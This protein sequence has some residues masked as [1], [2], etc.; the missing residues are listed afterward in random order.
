MKENRLIRRICVYGVGGVGGYF[1][2]KIALAMAEHPELNYECY[3]IARGPHLEAIKRDGLTV[4]SPERTIVA[5][6][7]LATD[8]IDAVPDPDLFLLCVKSYN[9]DDVVF[10]IQSKVTDET[11]IVPLLNGANIYDRIRKNLDTGIVLPACVFVG[12]HIEQPGVIRQ[13]GGDGRI[14]FGKDPG[15]TDFR[16]DDVINI[17]HNVGINYQWNDDPF[18]A[19]WRKFIF[20]AAFGLVTVYTGKSLGEIMAD[21]TDRKKVREVMLEIYSIAKAKGIELPTGIISESMEKAGQFPYDT[22]TSY[23]RDVELK[24]NINEGDLYGGTIIKEGR[25]L[26]VPTPVTS[27]IYGEIQKRLNAGQHNGEQQEN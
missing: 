4:V 12:T 21:D 6:P 8:N 11:I 23:Q 2:S 19:M 10:S 16:P 26:N 14:L 24:G 20:I 1:G 18:P 25:A 27:S 7:T 15:Y 22:K 17:F 13:E 5:R 9:L 3:F